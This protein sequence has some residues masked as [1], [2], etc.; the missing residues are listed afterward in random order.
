MYIALFPYSY[1][2]QKSEIKVRSRPHSLKHSRGYSF[3]ASCSFWCPTHYTREAQFL[4][5]IT[6]ISA[7]FFRWLVHFVSMSNLPL[8]FTYK[9]TCH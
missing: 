5:Y 6:P 7:S 1:G 2:D 3:L 9:D 4:G 8:P